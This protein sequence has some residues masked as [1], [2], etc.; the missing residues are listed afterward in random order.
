MELH[1]QPHAAVDTIKLMLGAW[2]L[3]YSNRDQRFIMASGVVEALYK[4]MSLAAQEKRAALNDHAGALLVSQATA[5]KSNEALYRWS[6]WSDIDVGKRQSRR[7]LLSILSQSHETQKDPVGTHR[8]T[9]V[10]SRR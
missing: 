9:H 2:A 7:A 3:N 5:D 8:C 1:G 6:P 4:L 10:C